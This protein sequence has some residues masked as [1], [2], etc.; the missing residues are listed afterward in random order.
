MAPCCRLSASLGVFVFH[1]L[2]LGTRALSSE[3]LSSPHAV[4]G[5]D[6]CLVGVRVPA[7]LCEILVPQPCGVPGQQAALDQF[8]PL[9]IDQ[10]AESVESF[11]LSRSTTWR[12]SREHQS[13][14]HAAYSSRGSHRR[15]TMSTHLEL[16]VGLSCCGGTFIVDSHCRLISSFVSR[17]TAVVLSSLTQAVVCSVCCLLD[18]SPLCLFTF[19]HAALLGC[20]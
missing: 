19:T 2:C 20:C 1:T 10:T 16:H 15:H 9:L 13:P 8:R 3:V 4:C 6:A 11:L 7:L 18:T 5:W 14:A 12:R 17:F